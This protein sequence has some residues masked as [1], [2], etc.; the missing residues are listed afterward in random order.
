VDLLVDLGGGETLDAG[1]GSGLLEGRLDQ[2]GD[3]LNMSLSIDS[4]SLNSI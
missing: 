2:G 1:L 3:F 4:S